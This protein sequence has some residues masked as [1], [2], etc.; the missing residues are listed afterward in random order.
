MQLTAARAAACW[1][2]EEGIPP[3]PLPNL[4]AAQSVE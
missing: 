2:Q 3:K 4:A 1:L